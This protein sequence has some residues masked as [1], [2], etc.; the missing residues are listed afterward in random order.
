MDLIHVFKNHEGYRSLGVLPGESVGFYSA[1][2]A[3]REW[4]HQELQWTARDEC[5]NV[6]VFL[7]LDD[8]REKLA[9]WQEDDSLTRPHSSLQ[10]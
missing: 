7:T 4:L 10:D 5:L 9:R 3:G 2:Q 1:R 6:E 8:A